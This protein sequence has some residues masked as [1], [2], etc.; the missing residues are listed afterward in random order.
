MLKKIVLGIAAIGATS[1]AL[2][3]A[4]EAQYYGGRDYRYARNYDGY[5]S[6]YYNRGYDSGYYNQGYDSR[7]YDRGYRGTSYGYDRRS[8]RGYRCG[9]GTTGAIVGGATGALLG[10]S[11]TRGSGYYGRGGSGTLG[12]I[13]GGTA[14]ALVG[15]EV[16]RGR[17]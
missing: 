5:Q 3:A 11:I 9:S 17:C 12:A 8:R 14:G 1:V 4:A 15:R 7:Y 13:I 16:S 10:R 2:P 6:G